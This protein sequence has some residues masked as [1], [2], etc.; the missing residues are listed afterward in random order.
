MAYVK[1]TWADGS[2]GGTPLSATALNDWEDR[3]DTGISS[4]T[5]G[6][7]AVSSVNGDTGAVVLTAAD[8]GARPD[9][10]TPG[11][12]DL[13]AWTTLTV[14]KSGGTWPS[15]PT[16]RTDI[17]VAWKGADPSPSIVSSG[18]GGMLNNVDYRLVT[19]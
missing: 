7:G 6:T 13:P 9:S 3:I 5:G 8:V 15:R 11:Y 17:V 18:T 4:V 19:P 12:A 2:G 10:Y 14:L 1:K 16:A